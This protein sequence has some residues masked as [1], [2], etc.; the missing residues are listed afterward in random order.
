[1]HKSKP[2]FIVHAE[3]VLSAH[4]NLVLSLLCRH[5]GQ[6]SSSL[7]SKG[8]S[9]K[10]ATVSKTVEAL[11]LLVELDAH[12]TVMVSGSRSN[13]FWTKST[14]TRVRIFFSLVVIAGRFIGKRC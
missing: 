14:R 9:G 4:A 5:G 11:M 10:P 8:L 7:V 2:K 1:M 12:S 3:L 6:L 13:F